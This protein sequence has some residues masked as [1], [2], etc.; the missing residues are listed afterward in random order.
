MIILLTNGTC[1][2]DMAR[3]GEKV[4]EEAEN[5][6]TE[7]HGTADTGNEIIIETK[8]RDIGIQSLSEP[9]EQTESVIEN[10]E[11]LS[12]S[13]SEEINANEQKTASDTI[14]EETPVKSS[15]EE[16]LE[17]NRQYDTNTIESEIDSSN[18]DKPINTETNSTLLSWFKYFLDPFLEE[19]RDGIYSRTN[20]SN[21]TDNASVLSNKTDIL[22][23]VNETMPPFLNL[24]ELNTTD[25]S[26]KTKF[27]CTGKNVTDNTNATVKIVTSSRLLQLLNF[28]KND[29]E[30]VTDC[31]VV[32]FYAPWCLF[33]A[34]TA[35]HYN[36][37]SRAFPQ[38]DFVAVDTAQFSKSVYH[39]IEEENEDSDAQADLSL[40]W[41][42]RSFCWF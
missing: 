2:S 4:V 5:P 32:M 42:H 36:A 8:G 31:L 37:L 11:K 34:K 15:G 41:M 1:G 25:S 6:N 40:R 30:N 22:K 16:A 10:D 33:C 23:V 24:T 19:F 17:T 38:L 21:A 26:K 20:Q 39:S 3:D 35:P 7:S 13:D 27:Q 12:I 18:N 14:L 29:T 9:R 28:D